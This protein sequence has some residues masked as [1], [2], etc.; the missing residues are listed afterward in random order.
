MEAEI[1]VVPSGKVCQENP[2]RNRTE[3]INARMTDEMILPPQEYTQ[4]DPEQAILNMIQS[5]RT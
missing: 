3:R 1:P 2:T 5:A 4:G